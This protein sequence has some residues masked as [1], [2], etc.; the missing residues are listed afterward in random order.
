MVAPHD[1]GT[2]FKLITIGYYTE[3]TMR[4]QN[5]FAAINVCL[6]SLEIEIHVK[7]IRN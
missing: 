6:I 7:Y 1:T 4:G 5:Y 3:I 2:L